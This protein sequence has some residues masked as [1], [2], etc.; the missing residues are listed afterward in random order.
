VDTASTGTIA[1]LAVGIDPTVITRMNARIPLTV[2]PLLHQFG[3]LV[4]EV[5]SG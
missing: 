1:S 4:T 3:A 2:S 5:S